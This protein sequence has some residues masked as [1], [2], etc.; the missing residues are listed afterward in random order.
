MNPKIIW[1][2]SLLDPS[3][4]GEASRNYV[5]SIDALGQYAIKIKPKY[6]WSGEALDVKSTWELLNRLH[7]T[8]VNHDEPHICIQHLTP[9]NWSIQYGACKYHIGMTTFE[10]DSIPHG[11]QTPMRSMDELWT[12]SQWG[13]EVFEEAGIRR[14][15]HVV[16]HGVTYRR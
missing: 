2:G 12:H 9:D 7:K 13:K 6:F 5:A 14:P 8:S 15:I 16:P 11:W 10:T 3:G 1:I 4:Y